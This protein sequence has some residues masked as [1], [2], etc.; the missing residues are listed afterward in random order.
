M[1]IV[2]LDTIEL[3]IDIEKTFCIEIPDADAEGL[4]VVGDLARYVSDKTQ[5]TSTECTFEEALH[6]IID[7]LISNYGI[8]V[9]KANSTSHVVFDLGLD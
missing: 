7:L 3:V 5:G 1:A 6:T 9:G 8:P 2:G 4:G